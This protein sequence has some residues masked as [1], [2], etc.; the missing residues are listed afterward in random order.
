MYALR[1]CPSECDLG[2]EP[3]NVSPKTGRHRLQEAFHP[4]SGIGPQ[5]DLLGRNP[6]QWLRELLDS[7]AFVNFPSLLLLFLVSIYSYNLFF[8]KINSSET[9]LGTDF[10]DS[11]Q[12]RKWRVYHSQPS[13]RRKEPPEQ[14]R[15][16]SCGKR[17]KG[18]QEVK[19]GKRRA[20]RWPHTDHRFRVHM[21]RVPWGW[22]PSS[23]P[24]R[25]MST[26]RMGRWYV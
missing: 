4:S 3:W 17:E 1:T 22:H 6:A 15:W 25:L 24:R 5:A 16:C 13:L 10:P 23:H 19:E 8:K 21:V 11:R 12:S 20:W 9:T 18:N 26:T 7:G 2:E 14:K